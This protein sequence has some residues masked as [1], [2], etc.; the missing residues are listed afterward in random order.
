[1]A[2][3]VASSVALAPS[4]RQMVIVDGVSRMKQSAEMRELAR[5]KT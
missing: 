4:P 5:G 2:V 1:M 3:A